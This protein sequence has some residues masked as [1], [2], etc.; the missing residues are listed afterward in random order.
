M[1]FP[2]TE[3][4]GVTLSRLICGTNWFLGYSHTSAAKDKFI[5]E[6][7][8]TPEK[9][10]AVI[11]VFGHHGINA[12]MGPASPLLAEAIKIACDRVGKKIHYVCTPHYEVGKLDTWQQAIDTAINYQATFCFPHQC[13]T[14]P[15]IDL[16]R[17]SLSE[18]L[19]LCLQMVRQAGMIP[20][21]SSHTPQAIVCA[22]ACG[23]DVESYIQPYNAAGFL[24]QVETDWIRK[25]ILQAKKPVMTIKPLAAGRI[26]PP[27]G[28]TFVWNS[29]RPC[30]LVTIGVVSPY[31]AEECIELSLAC[32]EK[33]PAEVELQFTRSKKSLV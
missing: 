18:E 26:L 12:V 20:G 27:T 13:M 8:P 14:D 23:A 28:L 1:G 6:L 10:A 2:T 29:I 9:I 32:L 21:L 17:R 31:E 19:Q 15:Q 3:V 16:V 11:E 30:D 5:R 7:F 33:R 4:G 22:D 24:C 25:I